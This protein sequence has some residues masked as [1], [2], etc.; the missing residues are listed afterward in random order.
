[1][2][3]HEHGEYAYVWSQ[4]KNIACSL[5]LMSQ[6]ISKYMLYFFLVLITQKH[7]DGIVMVKAVK[8]TKIKHN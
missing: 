5:E 7:I 2:D 6:L 3:T 1:M 4:G 8:H